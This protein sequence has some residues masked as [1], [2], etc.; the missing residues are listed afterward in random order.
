MINLSTLKSVLFTN[1]DVGM[2]I[3][4]P[5]GSTVPPHFHITE[6]GKVVKEFI[7]CGGTSRSVTSCNLQIYVAN[8]THHR[9]NSTKLRSIFEFAI[10]LFPS[11]DITVEIEYEC[12]F[13]A[14]FP[15]ASIEVND[16]GLLF[17][18][19]K[20]HTACLA[21]DACGIGECC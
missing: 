7:D 5:D 20:K 6:V 8:D 18:L 17:I 16:A 1:K 2:M 11:E 10:N 14:V 4:L 21:P 13:L 15:I 3:M 9:V 12:E 19:G